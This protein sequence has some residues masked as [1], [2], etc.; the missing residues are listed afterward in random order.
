MQ[1][2]FLTSKPSNPF[3]ETPLSRKPSTNP[4]D[5]VG[6]NPFESSDNLDSNSSQSITSW[7]ASLDDAGKSSP[8]SNDAGR[9]S[10]PRGHQPPSPFLT[11][12]YGSQSYLNRSSLYGRP[13]SSLDSATRFR[14]DE[15]SAITTV[16]A[17]SPISDG[18]IL[19]RTSSVLDSPV[20]SLSVQLDTRPVLPARPIRNL[21]NDSSGSISPRR[22]SSTSA[23][24]GR[25]PPSSLLPSSASLGSVPASRPILGATMTSDPPPLPARPPK[26]GSSNGSPTGIN[27]TSAPFTSANSSNAIFGLRTKQMPSERDK[28]HTPVSESVNGRPPLLDFG[29]VEVMHKGSVK[30]FAVSGTRMCTGSSNFRVWNL[31]NGENTRTNP[32]GDAKLVAMAFVPNRHPSDE[33][34]F[35]VVS[36][37]NVGRASEKGELLCLDVKTGEVVERRIAHQATVTHILRSNTKTQLWTIDENGGLKI[38]P[39]DT[40]GPG[41]VISL[42]TSKPYLLRISSRQQ[43]AHLTNNGMLWTASGK[44]VE[45]YN[46]NYESSNAPFQQR[47]DAGP[48]VGGVT[49]ITSTSLPQ[50]VFSSHDDGKVI[51][52]D[53]L[54]ERTGRLRIVNLGMYR[55]TSL[56]GVGDRYL[57]VGYSTGKIAVYDFGDS[58]VTSDWRVLKEWCA[59]HHVSVVD[60]VV[61]DNTNLE[62]GKLHVASMSEAGS[63]KMWDGLLAKDLYDREMTSRESEFSTVNP[64]KFF[65][66]SWNLDAAKPDALEGSHQ[67]MFFLSQWLS[68]ANKPDIIVIGLQEIIDLEST[69]ANA[70]K[71]F[72]G[73]KRANE[74]QDRDQRFVLWQKQLVTAIRQHIPDAMYSLVQCNVLVGLFQAV[75]VADAQVSRLR[76]IEAKLVKTGLGGVYGNKGAIAARFIFD[77]SSMCFVNCHLSAHVA[78]LASRNAD[79]VNIMTQCQFQAKLFYD[80]VWVNGGDGSGIMDHDFVVWA[81]DLNYRIDGLPREHVMQLIEKREWGV[82][83]DY[84]QLLRQKAIP[85]FPLRAL[86]EGELNFAPTFKYDRGSILYDTSEKKRVPAWCDRILYRATETAAP[87]DMIKQTSYRR[88]ECLVSD[89]RPIGSSFEAHVKKLDMS[90]RAEVAHRVRKKSEEH[91]NRVLMAVREDWLTA[92]CGNRAVARHALINTN[93]LRAARDLVTPIIPIQ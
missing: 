3:L 87:Y 16:I 83:R 31:A 22:D 27:S 45:S 34:R 60:F 26:H 73:S 57:W 23:A 82:L 39:E 15:P 88:Y 92:V 77:D 2:P 81:G 70:K 90:K 18:P 38:W 47:F 40:R 69:K 6:S 4:F 9:S 50:Y 20:R 21:T 67:D 1:N 17:S 64:I 66:G 42:I 29:A 35:V 52:W 58:A 91:F 84:D 71:F 54:P 85:S 68:T 12:T 89:H 41:G 10:P 48:H 55:T 14:P 11:N 65:V 43:V 7:I 59:Y 74:H 46:P 72:Q 80:N 93:S 25:Q 28:I 86:S 56:S 61:D 24:S 36:V 33:G 53:N 78:N 51:I 5:Q 19:L 63:M 44:M 13:S 75:F 8:P 76:D 30:C 79:I 49:G 37:E 32:L 62:S